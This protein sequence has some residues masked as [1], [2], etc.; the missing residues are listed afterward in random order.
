MLSTIPSV[1]FAA[2]AFDASAFAALLRLCFFVL[3]LLSEMA[4]ASTVDRETYYLEEVAPPAE[5]WPNGAPKYALLTTHNGRLT[6]QQV[7]LDDAGVV[8]A[9]SMPFFRLAGAPENQP[10]AGFAARKGKG[11]GKGALSGAAG[12]RDGTP[13]DRS[14]APGNTTT[15]P[16][17]DPLWDQW[18]GGA[19]PWRQAANERDSGWSSSN[20][21][22]GGW[23]S[24][25]HRGEWADSSASEAVPDHQVARPAPQT[26]VKAPPA[27]PA[28]ATPPA[29]L[30]APAPVTPP[31]LLTSAL[32][33]LA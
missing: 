9:S 7:E 20:W 31:T 18:R 15:P 33:D 3:L 16:A 21:S 32:N 11:R 6:R 14:R 24:G 30:T 28:A 19:V 1:A 12:W 4:A 5:A 8:R 26:P 10:G 23:N 13:A 27:T 22:A 17:Q 25:W 29:N 2:Q